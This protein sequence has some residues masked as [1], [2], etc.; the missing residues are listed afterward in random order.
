MKRVRY[1]DNKSI[2]VLSRF[3][4]NFEMSSFFLLLEIFSFSATVTG[5][6]QCIFL[7]EQKENGWD[8]VRELSE[9][10]GI[11]NHRG[12]KARGEPARV[13]LPCQL[14]STPQLFW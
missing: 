7:S 6:F 4:N 12:E 8:S 9:F 5:T 2:Y 1:K 13:S 11:Y 3:I 14:E 10:D